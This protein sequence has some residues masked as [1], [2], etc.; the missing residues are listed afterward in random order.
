[1]FFPEQQVRVFLYGIPV[2]MRRSFDGC[3]GARNLRRN[4]RCL[5]RVRRERFPELLRQHRETLQA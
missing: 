3:Y 1:M 4:R 2:D 5:S